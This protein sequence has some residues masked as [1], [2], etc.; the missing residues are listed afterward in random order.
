MKIDR[1]TEA[2]LW[3]KLHALLLISGV[4]ATNFTKFLHDVAGL[5]P[6]YYLKVA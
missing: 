1:Q 6:C 2:E 3:Q 4:T 5:S